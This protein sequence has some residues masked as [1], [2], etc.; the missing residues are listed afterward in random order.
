MKYA[1][2]QTGGKQ[3]RVSEGDILE[4]ERLP[5]DPDRQFGLDVL[6]YNADGDLQIGKPFVDGILVQATVLADTKGQKLRVSKFKSKVRFRRVTGHRQ[7]LSQIKIDHIGEKVNE[8]KR[9]V[10]VSVEEQAKVKTT[11]KQAK[12]N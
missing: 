3:Y 8:A 5:Y 4:V 12:K 2:I 11:V 9:G 6:L 1:V 7:Y 10:S